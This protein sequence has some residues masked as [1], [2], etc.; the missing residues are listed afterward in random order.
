MKHG[1]NIR[2]K[3]RCGKFTSIYNNNNNN[4]NKDNKDK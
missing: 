4:N 2:E 3:E 1:R